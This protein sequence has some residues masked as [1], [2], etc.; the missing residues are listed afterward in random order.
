MGV[1]VLSKKKNFF[2]KDNYFFCLNK[3]RSIILENNFNQDIL[4]HVKGI[5]SFIDIFRIKTKIFLFLLNLMSRQFSM[6]TCSFTTVGFKKKKHLKQLV[7]QSLSKCN[8][9]TCGMRVFFLN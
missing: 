8:I 4:T 1:K 6:C 2:P 7:T 9:H 5:H 3:T